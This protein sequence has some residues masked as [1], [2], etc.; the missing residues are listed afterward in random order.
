M[1]M[2]IFWRTDLVI[3]IAPDFVCGL[4]ALLTARLSGAQA[5]LHMQDFEVDIAFRMN[6]L[7][8][9]LL[10]WLIKIR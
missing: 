1:L 10:R 7:E 9:S 5:W 3:A 4:T 2:Q 8:G 6:P